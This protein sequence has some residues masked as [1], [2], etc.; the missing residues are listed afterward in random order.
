[1]S[2]ITVGYNIIEGVVSVI[3]GSIAGS[4]ALV[5]FGIDSFLESLSGGIMIWRFRQHGKISDEEEERVE[6]KAL[7]FVAYT[8]FILAAYVLYESV[9]KLVLQEIPDPSILG[10]IIATVS[11]ITMPF[12]FY[13]KYRTG[14]ALNS[15]SLIAD[16][17]E[18]LACIFL[19]VAL[20]VGLG[21][22]YWLGFWQADPVVGIIVVIYLTREG[23]ATLKDEEK[24]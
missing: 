14:K 13:M 6:R 3:I 22:N 4:I 21:L 11:I 23:Y 16:S 8:F 12:L 15:K 2:Y 1:M 7:R 24:D 19:S 18:T 10:I 20:F 5:G 9:S 17:K